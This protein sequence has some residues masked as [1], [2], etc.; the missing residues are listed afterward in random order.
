MLNLMSAEL[1]W[2][3]SRICSTKSEYVLDSEVV[4]GLAF[5]ASAVT[6]RSKCQYQTP[7]FERIRSDTHFRTAVV[8]YSDTLAA[9]QTSQR[10]Q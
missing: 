10:L 7:I 8:A 3:T 1:F 5:N 6:S 2:M 9:P 4:T